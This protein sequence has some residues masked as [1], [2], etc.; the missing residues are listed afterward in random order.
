MSKIFFYKEAFSGKCNLQLVNRFVFALATSVLMALLRAGAYLF[1][2][3]AK[4]T[5]SL[6]C[7]IQTIEFFQGRALVCLC[8]I[9][10]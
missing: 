9:F 4:Q 1:M 7:G 8:T 10:L 3:S 5:G 6:T 2:L